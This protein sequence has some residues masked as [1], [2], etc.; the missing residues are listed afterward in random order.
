[1][2]NIFIDNLIDHI[3]ENNLE[4]DEILGLLY[5]YFHDNDMFAWLDIYTDNNFFHMLKNI[6]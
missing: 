1:M 4:K 5:K 6:S 3:Q 2:S